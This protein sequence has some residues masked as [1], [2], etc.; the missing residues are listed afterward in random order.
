M[1]KDKGRLV[2]KGG[3][4]F[5]SVTGLVDNNQTIVIKNN[6]IAWVDEDEKFDKD[7]NDKIISAKGNFILPGMIDT[8]VHLLMTPTPQSERLYMRT[9]DLMWPYYALK[10][11]Q[12]HLRAGFTCVRDCGGYPKM[13]PSLK[14]I[15]D[16]S[17]LAGPR[18][19]NCD[20]GLVQWGFHE[21]VGPNPLIDDF[22][23]YHEVQSG[24]DG[25]VHAVRTR[26]LNG[27]DFIKTLTTGGILHGMTSKLETSFW[28]N[29]E[30]EAMVTEAHRTNMHVG[31]HA[32]G[33]EGIYRAVKA[34][35]DTIE[36]GT[37]M[38]EEI[39]DLMIKKGTYLIPTHTAGYG[40]TKPEI[41]KELPP[42]VVKKEKEI[43]QIWQEN[44]KMAFAKGV[45][46]AVGTD[47]GTPG[48]PHGTSGLEI[49]SYIELLGMSPNQ[50][51]Q[52]ATIEAAKAIRQD[53][54]LGS[55]ES[56]KMADIVICNQN[57]LDDIN[58]LIDLKN[59][60]YIIK[61]GIIMV[62][63]GIITHY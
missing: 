56:K 52:A 59:F 27:A 60:E 41:T 28:T 63:R 26:K 1:T 25:V 50:A 16:M 21:E 29:E 15:L 54:I 3:D 40:I 8:H 36:H 42:E 19:V 9:N 62:E 48:N 31:C 4:I 20:I 47:A 37:F 6:A 24:I 11:A 61:D 18:I 39:A 2:I 7:T 43:T 14:R 58:V 55:I 23:K 45:K 33:K 10:Q 30:L 22:I 51:L 49:K 46:I 32:H 13:I 35:I 44:H 53:D 12:D 34:D 57:P 17:V 38:D 5:N